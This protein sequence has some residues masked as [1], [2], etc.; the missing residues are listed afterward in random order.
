MNAIK[1]DDPA[2]ATEKT[3]RTAE[4]VEAVVLP[5]ER[6]PPGGGPI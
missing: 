5:Y 6:D 1:Y 2:S 4:F 3:A